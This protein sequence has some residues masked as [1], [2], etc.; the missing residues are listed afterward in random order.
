MSNGEISG[1]GIHRSDYYFREKRR[2][3]EV[4]KKTGF[5]MDAR[6]GGRPSVTSI[7]FNKFRRVCT[8]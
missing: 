1:E 6:G 8:Q 3:S 4:T 5:N 2:G 7:K